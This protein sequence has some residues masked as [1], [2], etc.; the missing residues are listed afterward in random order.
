MHFK[1]TLSYYIALCL[2][3]FPLISFIPNLIPISPSAITISFR[4]L[5]FAVS[6]LIMMNWLYKHL[7]HKIRFVTVL[8]FILILCYLLRLSGDAHLD[9]G[10]SHAEVLF[11]AITVSFIPA[12]SLA[13]CR[14]R[15]Q[16]MK[17]RNILLNILVYVCV[18]ALVNGLLSGFQDR[19]SGNSILNPITLGHAAVTG[20]IIILYETTA[21]K[22]K[23]RPIVLLKAIV[24]LLAL[25]LANSRGPLLCF[26]LVAGG[27]YFRYGGK[28]TFSSLVKVSLVL[29][30]LVGLMGL[31]DNPFNYLVGR[32][33]V[34][35]G[36]GGEGGEARVFLW[37][38]SYQLIL[39]SPFFGSQTT[40]IFGYP[41]NL[42]LEILMSVG[43]FGFLMFSYVLVSTQRN[44]RTISKINPDVAWIFPILSQHFIGSL[45]SG[46]VYSSNLFWYSLGVAIAVT[47]IHSRSSAVHKGNGLWKK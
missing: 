23:M 12:V 17:A 27:I 36:D 44:I 22:Q 9:F 19:L 21:L 8:S 39:S 7:S 35:F 43:L 47:S 15:G 6:L 26:I 40:T 31:Y 46:A 4:G 13:M 42:V 10:R 33:T 1:N 29:F 38:H 14:H 37:L 18:L 25:I 24:L 28:L 30:I 3:G 11:F 20:L 34:D 16:I 5:I 45:F 32:L 41:H 2:G